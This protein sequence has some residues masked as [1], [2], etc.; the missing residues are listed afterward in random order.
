MENNKISLGPDKAAEKSRFRELS[1]DGTT[2]KTKTENAI[3]VATTSHKLW[4]ELFS[5]TPKFPYKF[6]ESLI[7]PYIR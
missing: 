5:G 6:K 2:E 7:L 1:T 3:P 4:L